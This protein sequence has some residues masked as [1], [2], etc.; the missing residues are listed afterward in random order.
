MKKLI[1]LFAGLGLLAVT[2]AGIGIALVIGLLGA[3]TFS[4]VRMMRPKPVYVRR[5]PSHDIPG[6]DANGFRV[7]NDG[8][9]TII[10]M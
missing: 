6:E 9:G 3:I 4:A 7:W 5:R 2:L 10:D 1:T 8:R